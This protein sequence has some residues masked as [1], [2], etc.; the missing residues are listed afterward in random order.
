M[1]GRREGWLGGEAGGRLRGVGIEWGGGRGRRKGGGRLGGGVCWEGVGGAGGGR[2]GGGWGGGG[3]ISGVGFWVWGEG[4]S[5]WL[6]EG[7]WGGR[8]WW[9]WGMGGVGVGGGGGGGGGG[10]WG[11]RGRTEEGG[12]GVGCGGGG[13]SVPV[14]FSIGGRADNEGRGG[15]MFGWV[16]GGVGGEVFHLTIF[17]SPGAVAIRIS[18]T[19]WPNAASHVWRLVG[20]GIPLPFGYGHHLGT[21]IG[22][23]FS[24]LARRRS[25]N[26]RWSCP[27]RGN[28]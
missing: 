7:G 18:P 19:R 2:G 27:C 4:R 16:K 22:T 15:G 13:E 25:G 1:L 3:E 11:V 23:R 26:A 6:R 10:G 21:S 17:W 28:N 5:G 14:R 24:R 8:G 12:V 20:G 9:G